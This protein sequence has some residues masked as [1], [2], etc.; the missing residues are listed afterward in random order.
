MDEHEPSS[1]TSI[2]HHPW[3]MNHHCATF[4]RPKSAGHFSSVGTDGC[5]HVAACRLLPIEASWCT[6]RSANVQGI[7]CW[8]SPLSP[9]Q[10]TVGQA[11]LLTAEPLSF[12]CWC[13]KPAATDGGGCMGPVYATID[14]VRIYVCLG[15]HPC[16]LQ[17]NMIINETLHPLIDEPGGYY[18]YYLVGRTHPKNMHRSSRSHHP[19][20]WLKIKNHLPPTS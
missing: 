6:Q 10:R 1:N 11:G 3:F 8:W 18:V 4:K 16:T 20:V 2:K 19:L 12:Y 13:N 5:W 7:W 14:P 9:L 15:V 17:P